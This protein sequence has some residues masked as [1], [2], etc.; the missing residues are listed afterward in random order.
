MFW[1]INVFFSSRTQDSR[2]VTRQEISRAKRT[3]KMY[4]GAVQL[5]G[6]CRVTHVCVPSSSTELRKTKMCLV[7]Y[8]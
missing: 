6:Q 7:P 4:G 5:V 8:W 2:I 1:T 3:V